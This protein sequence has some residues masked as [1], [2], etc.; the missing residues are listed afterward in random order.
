MTPNFLHSAIR[1]VKKR[2]GFKSKKKVNLA[3]R[4]TD[5]AVNSTENESQAIYTEVINAPHPSTIQ[6]PNTN[7]LLLQDLP[8]RSLGKNNEVNS[9]KYESQD[10]YVEMANAPI[11]STIQQNPLLLKDLPHRSLGKN[12]EVNSAKYESQDKYVEMANAPI[13]STIQQNP[14][15]LKDLPHRS[16]GKNI[17]VNS[18][19]YESQDK[20]VEMANAAHSPIHQGELSFLKDIHQEWYLC[21]SKEVDEC[22]C[23]NNLR[24]SYVNE[25][26]IKQIILNLEFNKEKTASILV[27]ACQLL[28]KVVKLQSIFKLHNIPKEITELSVNSCLKITRQLIKASTRGC[29]ENCYSSSGVL[30]NLE[31]LYHEALIKIEDL[32]ILVDKIFI[33]Q[34][35]QD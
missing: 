13:R 9:A 25:L 21:C 29:M 30:K 19:K 2:L 5:T 1:K 7:P 31:I 10:K 26:H 20:Y 33:N 16:L 23:M 15:L 12:N 18:A 27:R 11:R 17:E 24:K 3:N 35:A 28:E 22:C 6:E 34:K 32:M 8:H 4:T 14:L